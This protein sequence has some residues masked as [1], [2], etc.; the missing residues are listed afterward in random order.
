MRNPDQR[1]L[2][3]TAMVAAMV[4]APLARAESRPRTITFQTRTMGTTAA[5]TLVTRD[6]AAVAD[7]AY[8]ALIN[9]HHTDSLLTN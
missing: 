8:D 3:F 5:L 1:L 4:C 6:S 2:V 9:L 7:L